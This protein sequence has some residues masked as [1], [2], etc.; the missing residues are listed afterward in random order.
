MR[1]STITIISSGFLWLVLATVGG[2]SSMRTWSAW[3][4]RR[5]S[6]TPNSTRCPARSTEPAGRAEECTNTSPPSSRVRKPN[7][8]S[9]SY[10]L[11]L[12]VGTDGPHAGVGAGRHARS[13]RSQVIGPVWLTA[14]TRDALSCPAGA[15][16]G[17]TRRPPRLPPPGRQP[18]L[19]PAPGL[20]RQI[21]GAQQ[22]PGPVVV[23]HVQAERLRVRPDEMTP[24][25]NDQGGHDRAHQRDDRGPG[26]PHPLVAG[27]P[28]L[29]PDRHHATQQR[30]Y[31]PE[32]E[33]EDEPA[34]AE[35]QDR[36]G[37]QLMQAGE[38]RRV[39]GQVHRA[40][41]QRDRGAPQRMCAAGER[42]RLLLRRWAGPGWG[43]AAFLVGAG[44][45]RRHPIG[46][47]PPS[48]VASPAAR[49]PTGRLPPRPVA[50]GSGRA[51]R[52]LGV[53][54][55]RDPVGKSARSLAGRGAGSP[56]ACALRWLASGA[57]RC[58]AG[59]ALRCLAG[60]ALR[61]LAR[62]VLRYL[63]ARGAGSLAGGALRC[64]AGRASG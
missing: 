45:G 10:H 49:P 25:T 20:Q 11:T 4:P 37:L 43:R 23:P 24:P 60:G 63:A 15:G 12:P 35:Q 33:H 42:G 9:A 58:L 26:E 50:G 22:A 14:A 59:G 7:P 2:G 64:L 29:R 21:D 44:G 13:T 61:C 52:C 6:A 46:R 28:D 30:E 40:V 62:S 17:I 47:L 19:R 5:P 8:L 41:A 32:R 56:A 16:P 39:Q 31:Q 3:T 48:G 1:S 27:I 55:A 18:S 51:A 57:L 54:E 34:D 53:R 38:V 36:G